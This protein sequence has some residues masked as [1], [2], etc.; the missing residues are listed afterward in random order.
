MTPARA[1]EVLRGWDGELITTELLAARRMG[2]DA[3]EFLTAFEESLRTCCDG[4]Q[5]E[6]RND[7]SAGVSEGWQSALDLLE[8][9]RAEW[10]K[11]RNE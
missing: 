11:E 8:R 4:A 10:E 2:A 9:L 6:I 5:E 1:A 3:L 7:R